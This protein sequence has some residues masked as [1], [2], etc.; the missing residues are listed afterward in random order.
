[1]R[2]K[3]KAV[4]K[5]FSGGFYAIFCIAF[6]MVCLFIGI[7]V[8]VKV[9]EVSIDA[10]KYTASA[11]AES[12]TDNPEPEPQKT[13]FETH[14]RAIAKD[15]EMEKELVKR[16][17]K[18]AELTYFADYAAS[19]AFDIAEVLERDING[20]RVPSNYVDAYKWYTISI[21]L[22]YEDTVGDLVIWG[23][24]DLA[25]LMTIDQIKEAKRLAQEWMEKY[26]GAK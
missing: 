14:L 1:M 7:F 17:S 18:V 25:D 11:I 19:A 2:K 8:A 5:V 20:R 15:A 4:L 6:V 10:G 21:L 22:G 13:D 3:I 12:I 16:L 9:L 23:R 24:D 26:G